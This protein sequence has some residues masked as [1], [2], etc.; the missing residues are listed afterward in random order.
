MTD[1]RRLLEGA[2]TDIECNLLAAD[3]TEMPD[4]AAKRRAA[5]ALAIGTAS[6]WPV[7]AAATTKASTKVSVSLIKLLLIG[8]AGVGALGTGYYLHSRSAAKPS[9]S[10]AGLSAP[11]R[12]PV[13]PAVNAKAAD[14]TVA[15]ATPPAAVTPLESL[16][17]ERPSEPAHRAANAPAAP[18]APAASISSEIRMLDAA[19]RAQA[20]G[21]G[22]GAIRA[23]DE[24]KKQYPHGVLAEES[25]LLRIEALAKL[26]NLSAAR[27]LAQKFRAAHPDSP[28]LRRIDSVLAAP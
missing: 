8:A 3:S 23:L 1:P 21:D 20:S 27:A 2:G 24:Y 10:A 26:G 22:A 6:M 18:S 14:E 5:M 9:T 15:P 12:G 19:R 13:S 25:S 28:H 17:R 7:A 16:E 11:V 4:A